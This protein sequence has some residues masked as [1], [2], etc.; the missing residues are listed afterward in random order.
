[1]TYVDDVISAMCSYSAG[2]S[3]IGFQIIVQL[4]DVNQVHKLFTNCTTEHLF[5]GPITVQVEENG[6]YYVVIFPIMREVGIVDTTIAYSGM[7]STTGKYI[8]IVATRWYWSD[9]SVT[10]L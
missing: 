1:M 9:H 5:P 6:T 7:L 8:C 3:V 4:D 10:S 2:S